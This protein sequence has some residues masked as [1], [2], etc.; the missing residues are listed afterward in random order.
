MYDTTIINTVRRLTADD[1]AFSVTIDDIREALP[2]SASKNWVRMQVKQLTDAQVLT[3]VGY[4]H[5]FRFPSDRYPGGTV[6]LDD[7][8]FHSAKQYA[9]KRPLHP[10]E[11]AWY[12]PIDVTIRY[13]KARMAA[14]ESLGMVQ[15]HSQRSGYFIPLTAA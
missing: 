3:R 10:Y 9:S 11:I 12:V 6:T 13:V 15:R 5:G 2:Y 4:R 14:M 8:I 1:G 7:I